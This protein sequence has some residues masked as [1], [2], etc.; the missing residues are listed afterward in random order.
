LLRSNPLTLECLEDRDV[1]SVSF[2]Y[3][4][5]VPESWK[6]AIETAGRMVMDRVVGDYVV[7]VRAAAN[8]DALARAAPTVGIIIATEPNWHVG[9]SAVGLDHLEFSMVSV[10][11][12][13]LFHWLGFLDHLPEGFVDPQLRYANSPITGAHIIPGIE[14]EPTEA[15]YD[16]L[17][18]LGYTIRDRAYA[19]FFVVSFG[20]GNGWH[21]LFDDFDYDGDLDVRL[22]HIG[23]G[24]DVLIDGAGIVTWAYALTQ[25]VTVRRY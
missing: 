5:T 6:P 18:N 22:T 21:V 8:I 10:V 4:P 15:D 23:F 1:C 3:D 20:N 25:P 24:V 11:G 19:P 13:E 2:A 9:T 7:P 16:T 14:Y 12:H 17:R